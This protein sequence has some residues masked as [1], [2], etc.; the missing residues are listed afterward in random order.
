MKAGPALRQL[1]SH[2][3][4]HDGGQMQAKDLTAI[5]IQLFHKQEERTVTRLLK[6]FLNTGK[7]KSLPMQIQKMKVYFLI[8]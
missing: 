5:M 2:R 8:S 1:T 3:A 6:T 7:R 4:I